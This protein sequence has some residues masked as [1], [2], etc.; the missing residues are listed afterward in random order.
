VTGRALIAATA[1]HA[2]RARAGWWDAPEVA[3]IVAGGALGAWVGWRG[4]DDAVAGLHAWLVGVVVIYAVA[5]L[6]VPFLV[7]WRADAGLLAQLPIE[8]GALFAA[9]LWRCVGAAALTTLACALGAAPAL[10]HAPALAWRVA[11]LLGALGAAT[12]LLLPAVAGGAAA[13]VASSRGDAMMAA[14]GGEFRA[15]PTTMLGAAP[16]FIASVLIV[17]VVLIAPWLVGGEPS[18]AAAPTLAAIVAV[19]V[20]G[21]ALAWRGAPGFM[22]RVLRDVSALDRQR[23]ATLEIRPPTAIEAAIARALGP[24][25]LT[26]RKDAQLMRRRYP[27]AYVGGAAAWMTLVGVAVSRPAD[28]A[29]W[30]VGALVGAAAYAT[31]LAGRLVRAPIELP[32]LLPTLPIGGADAARAKRAWMAGW[33]AVFVALPALLAAPWLGLGVVGGLGGATALVVATGGWRTRGR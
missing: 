6:R 18:L 21:I 5:M 28:P 14:V 9:A 27:M 30:L 1:R 12:G 2:R 8:G 25:G 3:V 29:P 4:G 31:L 11:A 16:G 17:L 20:V 26:Y 22:P 33:W 19:A 10:I 15:P 32:R 7:Y 23:L 24:A 13:L